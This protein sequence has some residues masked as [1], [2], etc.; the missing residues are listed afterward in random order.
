MSPKQLDDSIVDLLND[1]VGPACVIAAILGTL[2]GISTILVMFIA[3][4]YSAVGI[5]LMVVASTIGMLGCFCGW[6]VNKRLEQ[7]RKLKEIRKKMGA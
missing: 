2:A 6:L 7:D 3:W 5:R 1:I 4:R